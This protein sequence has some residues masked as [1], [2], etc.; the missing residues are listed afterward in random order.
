[1]SVSHAFS[2]GYRADVSCG[3]GIV[4]ALVCREHLGSTVGVRRG[5]LSIPFIPGWID[6]A[7]AQPAHEIDA[8]SI[9]GELVGVEALSPNLCR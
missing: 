8:A 4:A 5:V 3:L 9:V 1:M 2:L 7:T 6:A